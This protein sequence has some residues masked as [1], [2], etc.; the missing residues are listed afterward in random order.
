MSP[1][2]PRT[3]PEARWAELDPHPGVIHPEPKIHERIAELLADGWRP[4]L[5][6]TPPLWRMANGQT[7]I[8]YRAHE[9]ALRAYHDDQLTD[10]DLTSLVD[11]PDPA[12]AY[13]APSPTVAEQTGLAGQ[14]Q[15]LAEQII[16]EALLWPAPATSAMRQAA[17]VLRGGRTPEGTTLD[18]LANQLAG[19]ADAV[20][21]VH[22]L[23]DGLELG[24]VERLRRGA[25]RRVA[26]AAWFVDS[27]AMRALARAEGRTDA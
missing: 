10:D 27:W 23:T 17:V 3:T 24:P 15:A 7:L 6:V 26:T 21:A 8:M 11:A 25:L 19:I 13:L 18:G 20:D 2:T 14:I 9:K 22:A 12:S 16:G 5:D 4:D 1:A